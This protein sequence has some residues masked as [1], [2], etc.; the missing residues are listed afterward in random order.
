MLEEQSGKGMLM[1]GMAVA[2]LG[3]PKQMSAGVEPC[4]AP[5]GQ[6]R[7]PADS[8]PTPVELMAQIP[9]PNLLY[10]LGV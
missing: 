5:H 1:G 10:P 9:S 6:P 8:F 4:V 3:C 7:C 2:E